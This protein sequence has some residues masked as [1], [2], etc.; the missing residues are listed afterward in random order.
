MCSKEL[1]AD[2]VYAWPGAE[3]AV[4]GAEAAVDVL[5]RKSS[6]E[7]KKLRLA[8]YEEHFLSPDIAVHM[9]YVDEIIEPYKTTVQAFPYHF[10]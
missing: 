7:E 10:A 1:G 4:M 2:M 9:G 3:M 6:E 8:E 5:F